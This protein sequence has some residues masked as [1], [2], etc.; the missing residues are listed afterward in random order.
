MSGPKLREDGG[1][2]S[3]NV[4]TNDN[5]FNAKD[6]GLYRCLVTKVLY[7]ND[8]NNINFN[9]Q[10][11]EVLYECVILGGWRSGNIISNV[12]MSSLL[13]GDY[14][15]EER[16]LR[17]TSKKLHEV[18][19]SEQDGDVVYV[20]FLQGDPNY[21]VIVSLATG[22]S[23]V[24][25]TGSSSLTGPRKVE[26]YNGVLEHIN[27]D[28]ELFLTRKGGEYNQTQDLFLPADEVEETDAALIGN[29]ETKPIDHIFEAEMAWTDNNMLWRD[30]QS[31]ILFEQT[32]KKMSIKTGKLGDDRPS[33]LGF[34]LIEEVRDGA[35][36]KLTRTFLN[37]LTITEDALADKMQ[38]NFKNGLSLVFNGSSDSVQIN[39]N[40]GVQLSIDG[41]TNN[42]TGTLVNGDYISLNDGNIEIEEKGGGKLRLAGN[43]VALG[44]SG[45]E[46][47]DVIEDTLTALTTDLFN[48]GYPS[49]NQPLYVALLARIVALKGTL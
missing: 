45:D 49:M 2:Q 3:S 22:I 29:N 11:P 27:K 7:V 15:Y 35:N 48:L 18:A 13:G 12:K 23:D 14:N 43:Q 30:N 40:A 17:P 5:S 46:V 25:K 16:I 44:N 28:G 1:F 20:Q 9:A 4:P 47:L 6:H 21:P 26:Q 36:Q 42:I 37:G 31:S 8:P 34:N 10:N 33:D 24:R 39:T 38:F 41:F 19:L 32:E